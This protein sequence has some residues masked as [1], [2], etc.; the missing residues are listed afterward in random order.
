LVAQNY[1]KWPPHRFFKFPGKVLLAG[2]ES[3]PHFSAMPGQ[4]DPSYGN[5]PLIVD[6]DG[7]GRQDIFWLND[8]G[9]SRAYLN[10]SR[11]DAVIVAL[12]DAARSLGARA[13]IVGARSVY[14]REF[15]T[16]I[17]LGTDQ[18][19]VWAFAVAPGDRAVRLEVEWP[20]GLS[21]VV[22]DP[23]RNQRIEIDRDGARVRG[24][25]GNSTA[26]DARY[27]DSRARRAASTAVTRSSGTSS[28]TGAD[29]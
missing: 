4:I 29:G 18:S 13:R 19:P 8:D 17:G 15:S 28:G 27:S 1:V 2:P 23:P 21:T 3:P 25:D 16:S 20:N 5:A 6:L 11:G 22:D 26:L 14:T 10:R 7:D 9:P 12:P 24:S